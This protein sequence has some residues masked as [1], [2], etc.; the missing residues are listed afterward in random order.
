MTGLYGNHTGVD[1]N[2]IR[3]TRPT[4]VEALHD[5]GYRTMLAGKYLNS[6]G[7]CGP[8][9]EFDNWYCIGSGKSSYSLMDP[10]VYVKDEVNDGWHEYVSD[11]PGHPHFYTTDILTEAAA[12]FIADT[13]SDV[14]FFVM[15]TPTSP[16]LPAN[17]DRCFELPVQPFRGGAFDEATDQDGKPL[18]MARPPLSQSEV[19]AI[20]FWH[21]RMTQAVSCL[22]GS[23]ATLLAGLGDR[24]ASTL[25]IY[26]SDNGYLYGEHRRSAK[27][28]P[29]DEVVR[30]PMVVRYPPLVS[31][32]NP[33][34][35][36]AL[37][38]NVDLAPTIADLLGIPW[39]ADG[40]SLV[41]LLDGSVSSL[42]DALLLSYCEGNSFP[43]VSAQQ[44]MLKEGKDK[45]KAQSVVPSWWKVVTKRFAYTDYVTGEKELYDLGGSPEGP[46]EVKNL[47]ADP[48]Y[49]DELAQLAARLAVLRVLPPPE[50][51]IVTGPSG[52][53]HSRTFDFTY[54]TQSRRGRYHCRLTKDGDSG[55]WF[56][57]NGQRTTVG[58][59]DD[60]AYTFEVAAT[61][62][63]GSIDPTPASRSFSIATTGPAVSITSG[64]PPD[65]PPITATFAF[66]GEGTSYECRLSVY[67]AYGSKDDW[68]PC[69]PA[70]PPSYD[71]LPTA[72]W[73]FEVRASDDGGAT[74]D[75]PAQW[76][77]RFDESGPT[78]DFDGGPLP[79]SQARAG[80]ITF[81]PEEP[82]VGPVTCRLD[83]GAPVDCTLG[84]FS[85]SGLHEGDHTLTTTATD[86]AGDRAISSLPWTID[87]TPPT[88]TIVD[89]PPHDTTE[90][91]AIFKLR[92]DE[93]GVTFYCRLDAEAFFSH[94]DKTTKPYEK[95]A[96]GTHTFT[97]MAFDR[98]QNVSARPSWTWTIAGGNRR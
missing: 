78:M 82:V 97:A 52:A 9:P 70:S 24:A 26:L 91:T 89:G 83:G 60:G 88:V 45:E 31:E 8:R 15:Y 42:R 46:D 37:A 4:I 12:G 34:S 49:A 61:N 13:P 65:G 58:P 54:F 90:T 32:S 28:V 81:D 29:Y 66:S 30:M 5:V 79:H 1:G 53:T 94:C 43:C 22:D 19:D 3:L 93:H 72:L 57:C 2:E 17:D 68:Q 98:A 27:T 20:D 67:S 69:D 47:A 10:W 35:L 25:V 80:M 14:P 41:P 11:P 77:F 87:R 50:T 55:D 75:P 36:D 7:D 48:D 18:Y 95:L 64:P 76:L 73:L 33:L 86:Q 56:G 44:L 71:S 85:Y 74:T 62:P 6:W 92:A 38:E 63:D 40:K 39:G 51:T 96:D 23:I 59:L 21:K 16:H 84:L